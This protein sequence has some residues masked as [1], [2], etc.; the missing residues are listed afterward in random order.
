MGIYI[1]ISHLCLSSLEIISILIHIIMDLLISS[2][3]DFF[4]LSFPCKSIVLVWIGLFAYLGNCLISTRSMQSW[5]FLNTIALLPFQ[6][7]WINSF[8]QSC[9]IQ[10]VICSNSQSHWDPIVYENLHWNNTCSG[11]LPHH[12]NYQAENILA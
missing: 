3:H 12:N 9:H 11:S 1:P 4:H 6:C 8:C 2:T 10:F 5:I 7:I